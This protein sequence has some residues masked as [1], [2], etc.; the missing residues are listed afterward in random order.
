ME[1]QD[2]V[3]PSHQLERRNYP[4]WAGP[5]GN[6]LDMHILGGNLHKSPTLLLVAES[7]KLLKCLLDEHKC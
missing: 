4:L 3:L 5:M 2:L 6:L 1:V 7:F